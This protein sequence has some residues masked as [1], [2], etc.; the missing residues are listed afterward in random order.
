MEQWRQEKGL[1]Q[2]QLARMMGLANASQV[3]RRE[4]GQTGLTFPEIRKIAEIF[5]KPVE[6][7]QGHIDA[8][9][10][11]HAFVPPTDIPVINRAPAGT[12][13]PYD[14]SQGAQAEY[15]DAFEYI[16]RLDIADPAAF[17]VIVVGDS[18]E[19]R[20]REGDYCVCSPMNVPQP[21]AQLADGAAVFVRFSADSKHSG[22]TI[23]RWQK[24]DDG[25]VWL[26]KD[27][28]KYKTIKCRPDD[29]E[30]V[31]VIVELRAKKP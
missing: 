19:P 8:A 30:R 28:P 25:T 6:E 4:S 17:A 20:I 23:A 7:I 27:N 11:A 18:M 5:G 21:R 26:T 2:S 31:A 12:V 13:M 10:A 15:H 16:P 22:C 14:H 1:T 24:R 9:K 29:L 3:S